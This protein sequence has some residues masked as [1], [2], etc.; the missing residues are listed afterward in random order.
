MIADTF[1]WQAHPD[2]IQAF[3]AAAI[4][5]GSG[6]SSA[7]VNKSLNA[8]IIGET[9]PRGRGVDERAA[10]AAAE[11]RKKAAAR[12]LLIRPHGVPV[13]AL[14]PINQLLNIINSGATPEAVDD[15]EKD[16]PKD[17]NG[18]SSN[19]SV[20]ASKDQSLPQQE[21]QAPAGLGKGLASLD[22]KKQKSKPKAAA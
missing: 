5:G 16:G 10:R 20:D 15:K 11:V 13:Q 4:A 7:S 9:L 1:K 3:Q 19:G 18:H 6:N 2:L 8:A 22:S 17:A 12:G 14:P 21:G